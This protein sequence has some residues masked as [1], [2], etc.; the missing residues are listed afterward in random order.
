VKSRWLR[1]ARSRVRRSVR[2]PLP[3]A[4]C[5]NDFVCTLPSTR[6]SVG[7]DYSH[8]LIAPP[9][10]GNVGDQALVESFISATR[11]NVL[12]VVRAMTDFQL[13]G[14]EWSRVTI[15][16]M[17]QLIYGGPISHIRSLKRLRGLLSPTSH[18]SIVGADIMDGAYNVR[19]SVSRALVAATYSKLG[20]DVRILGFSWNGNP[21]PR[22]LSACKKASERGAS[23]FL[24]DPVSFARATEVGL[25]NTSLVAD[26]VFTDTRVDTGLRQTILGRIRGQTD[27]YAIVN[28]SALAVSTEVLFE[29]LVEVA[30]ELIAVGYTVVVV[31]HVSRAGSDDFGP[32]RRL[33][34]RLKPES[35]VMLDHLPTP[36]EVRGL[37]EDASIVITGR[38][39]LSIMS[40]GANV[41]AVTLATQGK[42][43]GLMELY[44]LPHLCV[45]PDENYRDKLNYAVWSTI[46]D[47]EIRQTIGSRTPHVVHLAGGNFRGFS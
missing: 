26:L 7:T 10:N 29:P 1:A 36:S 14:P 4:I 24:R 43:E 33:F 40:M 37:V 25:S 31:P 46:N 6:H 15:V 42:V 20:I 45:L 44:G 11:G 39:H 22:A 41:P 18:V 2:L 34:D 8:I 19:A 32:C 21:H 27:R 28:V 23:L 5:I 12:V 17:P 13:G 16:P 30:Q 3:L 9:G 35:A 47:A 38:M